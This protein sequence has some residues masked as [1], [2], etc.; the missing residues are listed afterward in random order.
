MKAPNFEHTWQIVFKMITL[1]GREIKTKTI[2][3]TEQNRS[4]SHNLLPKVVYFEIRT[5]LL[6][7]QFYVE[8]LDFRL[9]PFTTCSFQ[10]VPQQQLIRF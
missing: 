10:K 6:T 4:N 5:Q 8:G 7:L 1:L 3:K 9:S 2:L